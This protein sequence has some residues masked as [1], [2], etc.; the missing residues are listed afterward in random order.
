MTYKSLKELNAARD[1][2]DIEIISDESETIEKNYSIDEIPI[3]EIKPGKKELKKEKTI[4]DLSNK[5][6]NKIIKNND[7]RTAIVK[8]AKKELKKRK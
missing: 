3:K 5:E 7:G 4:S 2:H 6:L 8:E 1:F